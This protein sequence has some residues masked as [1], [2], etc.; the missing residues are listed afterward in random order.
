MKR[1]PERNHLLSGFALLCILLLPLFSSAQLTPENVELLRLELTKKV[2]GLRAELGLKPLG[3]D[4]VLKKAA[5]QHSDFMAEKNVLT[6]DETQKGFESPDKRIEKAGGNDFELSGE[7]VLF[8]SPVKLPLSKKDIA[9]VAEEMFQ[10]WKKSPGHYANMTEASYTLGDFG[11]TYDK[12]KSVIYATEVFGKR[13]VVV[14]GQLSNNG[15]GLKWAS[16]DCEKDYSSFANV[17]MHLG[18]CFSIEGDKVIMSYHDKA[19]LQ[20]IL[21]DPNDGIA[22]DLVAKDQFT[23][24]K[25]NNLD[26][27]KVYDGVLLQ[28][29]YRDE[30]F[31]RNKAKGDY[32]IIA[33]IGSIPAALQGKEMLPCVILI[34]NGEACKY[35]FP[36]PV[37]SADYPLIPI[38]PMWEDVK[39]TAWLSEGIIISEEIQYTFKTAKTQPVELP[40]ILGEGSVYSV[41]I[42]AYSSI[43]GDPVKNAYLDS[44]RASFIEQD[45]LKR[46][47]AKKE[48]IE[49]RHGENW[50]LNVFQLLYFDQQ[51]LLKLSHDSLRKVETRHSPIPLNWDSLLFEQRV[52][53]AVI[54]YSGKFEFFDST[55]FFEANLMTA[56]ALKNNDLFNKAAFALYY[57]EDPFP[58]VVLE[59]PIFE[60]AL[61]HPEV[62]AAYSAL[63]SLVYQTDEMTTTRF[64]LEWNNKVGQLSQK[65]KNNLSF[66]YALLG[67]QFLGEWDVARERLAKVIH[68][69]KLTQLTKD[70]TP[71]ELMLDVQLVFIEYFGQVNDGPNIHKSFQ[72]I[73]D[74]FKKNV[75]D[76]AD[77]INL[78]LFYN[79]WSM[80][81]MAVDVLNPYYQKKE[82]DETGLYTLLLTRTL[83]EGMN[84]SEELMQIH[85]DAYDM[86][87]SRWCSYISDC[88]NL[89]R[90]PKVKKRYCEKCSN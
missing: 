2:N 26:L 85:N 90:Y 70:L 33:E 22:V 56:V 44:M 30:L 1:I 77:A 48:V 52:A 49:K 79:S 4:V 38:E 21:S 60:Y 51:E 59:T 9:L 10:Q 76:V 34:N 27:S 89:L 5:Q 57:S 82:L 25:D 41:Q 61:E 71:V 8:S 84:P 20:K 54:N 50:D 31:A 18:N 17:V 32:R 69:S 66:L 39:E 40:R 46:T 86:N 36:I 73:S 3:N 78:A 14:S 67:T 47:E 58:L 7:N 42:Q 16:T 35:I 88:F 19:W 63:L 74:Y 83:I 6:H 80:N 53:K 75:L 29:V 12:D 13:G 28:P 68:P 43:E 64:V 87:P 55:A 62:V 37:P 11:F 23:C 24:G 65:A 81:E 45:V 15:F 72:F